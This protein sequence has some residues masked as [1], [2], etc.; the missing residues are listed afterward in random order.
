MGRRSDS[1]ST[2]VPDSVL[3]PNTVAASS[4]DRGIDA[5]TAAEDWFIADGS[6]TLTSSSSNLNVPE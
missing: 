5:E 3:C 1:T 2:S 6:P 4:S